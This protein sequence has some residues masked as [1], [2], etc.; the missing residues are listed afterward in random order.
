MLAMVMMLV[1]MMLRNV[2]KFGINKSVFRS[3][4]VRIFDWC[5]KI[6]FC[7]C[8]RNKKMVAFNQNQSKIV[9]IHFLLNSSP[10]CFST[11]FTEHIFNENRKIREIL[12]S[13]WISLS[14]DIHFIILF[15]TRIY[16][17]WTWAPKEN[18]S[19]QIYVEWNKDQNRKKRQEKK[20][21]T[22]I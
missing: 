22:R 20:E 18:I 19:I 12:T 13:F 2:K 7:H 14:F 1:W 3:T 16:L 5:I 15:F 8:S 17:S 10:T 9:H 4:L 11:F 6:F 21:H